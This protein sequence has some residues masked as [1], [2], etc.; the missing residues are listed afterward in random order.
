M[1]NPIDT[2][3]WFYI[4]ANVVE[5]G[6]QTCPETI[7]MTAV[8]GVANTADIAGLA[9]A[10]E[11]SSK[12]P[13]LY[14]LPPVVGDILPTIDCFTG[15]SAFT[16]GAFAGVLGVSLGLWIG[17]KSKPTAISRT[18]T[19]LEQCDPGC[20]QVVYAVGEDYSTQGAGF[21]IAPELNYESP[22][23]AS[24][25]LVAK[26]TPNT[27]ELT[28]SEDLLVP[29]PPQ[30]TGVKKP[31]DGLDSLLGGSIAPMNLI[32]A[33]NP[34]MP[35]MVVPRLA[36]SPPEAPTPFLP[37]LGEAEETFEKSLGLSSGTA[38]ACAVL[39][40][41]LSVAGA[42]GLLTRQLL[43][44]QM[45]AHS[46]KAAEAAVCEAARRSKVVAPLVTQKETLPCMVATK[47]THTLLTTPKT[48]VVS[49]RAMCPPE[50]HVLAPTTFSINTPRIEP[51]LLI[52]PPARRCVASTQ[53]KNA[54]TASVAA[55]QQVGCI[56]PPAIIAVPQNDNS[57]VAAALYASR[58]P[59]VVTTSAAV[60]QPAPTPMVMA[61][62]T[63]AVQTS[64]VQTPTSLQPR[65]RDDL[66]IVDASPKDITATTQPRARSD[67]LVPAAGTADVGYAILRRSTWGRIGKQADVS[68]V[69][70]VVRPTSPGHSK[71]FR[72]LP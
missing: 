46:M 44:H 13:S 43:K 16:V 69:D 59:P 45:A 24:S 28:D 17:S 11:I 49:P 38:K 15:L 72:V 26:V 29:P 63:S 36:P 57:A 39:C 23:L 67:I 64:A 22:R 33:T 7:P 55:A 60:H 21:D 10:A 40:L 70:G 56:T 2:A 42:G 25:A 27:V 53:Q 30:L 32:C 47:K 1:E 62:Q 52:L 65:P 34:Q 54:P 19:P 66:R 48:M 12:Q 35:D 3:D 9:T 68:V 4:G 20:A 14:G 51:K 6:T 58:Q 50:Q 41:G 61:P 8:E 71:I 5:A 31:F 18:S 37:S